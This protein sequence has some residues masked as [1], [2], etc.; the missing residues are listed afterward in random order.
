MILAINSC[1]ALPQM[2]HAIGKF[3]F[4]NCFWTLLL[5]LVRNNHRPFSYHKQLILSQ[6][7]SKLYVSF[8][9]ITKQ[10]IVSAQFND[11]IIPKDTFSNDTVQIY[12]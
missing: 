10:I 5:Y 6:I 2:D 9:N 7:L 3:V 11:N 8:Q 12:R 1:S 4:G